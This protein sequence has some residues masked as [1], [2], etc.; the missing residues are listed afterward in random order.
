MPSDQRFECRLD[1][2]DGIRD[3]FALRW[4]DR[5]RIFDPLPEQLGVT[6]L[7]LVDLQTLPETLIEVSEARRFVWGAI[8]RPYPQFPRFE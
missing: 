8:P 7:D 1:P 3:R 5:L 6:P 2:I 4:A